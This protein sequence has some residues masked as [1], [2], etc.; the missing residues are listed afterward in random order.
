VAEPGDTVAIQTFA[1]RIERL[2]G[3]RL[4]DYLKASL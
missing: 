4:V 3:V 1:R 2:C